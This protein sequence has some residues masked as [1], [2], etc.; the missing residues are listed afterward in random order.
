MIEAPAEFKGAAISLVR[1]TKRYGD[2]VATDD[3]DLEIRAGEF[4]TLLGPSGSGKTTTLMMIAGFVV[5]T[6]GDILIDGRSIIGM[7]P[8]KRNLGMVFQ[9][10]SLFPHMNVY[11][12]IAF[13]L[14]MR[15]IN[16]Q[17]IRARVRS[18]LKLVRLPEFEDR[19]VNQLSGGQQ[20]RI[21]FA[22]ALVYEPAVLLLDEPLG[23]LDLKL[24][25]EMQIEL[26]Q[27]H[28]RLGI[29]IIFVTHDQG[30]ALAMSDRIVVLDSGVIQ[31]VGT[32]EELYRKPV[33]RFVADFVGESNIISGTAHFEPTHLVLHTDD[34]LRLVGVGGNGEANLGRTAVVIRPESIVPVSKEDCL[35]NIFEGD[36][37]EVIYL[38][39]VVKYTI[40]IGSD[41]TVV[42][43]WLARA[44][45]NVMTRGDR[46]RIGWAAEDMVLV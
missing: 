30:E 36:V 8:S 7:P 1:L 13:P 46:V 18:A 19:R 37:Q 39:D 10:Y 27:L 28:E 14:E 22:R 34:G 43:K 40:R 2:V 4:V 44:S 20:Q 31:Q 12:N 35:P 21:A 26:L 45:V 5:P 29:T 25:Q 6:Q 17:D 16:R 3:I 32:P 41:T 11:S 42:A 38:G 23:A 9:S 15:R 24:R 33:N